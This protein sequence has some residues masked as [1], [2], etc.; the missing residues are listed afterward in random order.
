MNTA[1]GTETTV[2]VAPARDNQI[3]LCRTTSQGMIVCPA[4]A[5]RQLLALLESTPNTPLSPAE[6]E[7]L[8]AAVN[9]W[10]DSL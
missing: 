7:A 4:C 5:E 1:Q 9:G 6:R 2:A 8:S 10:F 3:C